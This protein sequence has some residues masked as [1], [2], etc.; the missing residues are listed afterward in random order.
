MIVYSDDSD[1][2]DGIPFDGSI[3]TTTWKFPH[4]DRVVIERCRDGYLVSGTIG[5]RDW[6]DE[7]HEDF[8]CEDTDA[9][10]GFLEQHGLLSVLSVPVV[11]SETGD[12]RKGTP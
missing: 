5:G 7:D 9:L 2:S 8:F 4:G 6:H 11:E 3:E 1:D 12:A 10:L